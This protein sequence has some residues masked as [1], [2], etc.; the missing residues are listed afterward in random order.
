MMFWANWVLGP[1]AGPKGDSTFSSNKGMV[2]PSAWRGIL[3]TPN[4]LPLALYSSST[5]SI[6]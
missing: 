4:T 3:L 6:S 5:Q 2:F 1:A